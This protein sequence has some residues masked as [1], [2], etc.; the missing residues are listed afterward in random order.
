MA[1]NEW[2]RVKQQ[3][4]T[5]SAAIAESLGPNK[6]FR[7][8]EVRVKFSAAIAA[9]EDL[10]VT[11]NSANGA[12]YDVVLDTQAMSGLSQYIFRPAAP[13]LGMKGDAA[14]VAFANTDARTYGIEIIYQEI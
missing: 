14:D 1:S 13:L 2:Y 4:A 7:I 9:A 5:G 10:T 6:A 8:L 11:L 3:S 12:S